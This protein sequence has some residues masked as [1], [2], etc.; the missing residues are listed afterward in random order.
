MPDSERRPP[1][2]GGAAAGWRHHVLAGCLA[3]LTLDGWAQPLPDAVV[4]DE[5]DATGAAYY[6]ASVPSVTPPSAL[7]TFASPYGGK[8]PILTQ[9]RLTGLHSGLLEWKP[10]PGGNWTW[11]IASPNFQIRNLTG[12]SNLVLFLNGPAAVPSAALPRIGLESSNNQRSATALLGSFLPA[13]LDGDTSTWQRVVVPLPAFAPFGSFTPEQFKAMFFAQG[14]TDGVTRTLWLDNVRFTDGH[15]P[16]PPARLTARAGDRSVALHWPRVAEPDIAGYQVYRAPDAGGPWTLLTPTPLLIPCHAD[17]AVT[18]GQSACYTVRAL[19][20]ARTESP[21]SST[22]TATPAAFVDDDAFLELVARTSFDFFWNEANPTN[23]LIRDRTT[24]ASPVSIAAVGFGLSGIV[25]AIERGWITREEGR[26]RVL[27]TLRTFRDGPQGSATTGMIGYQG[28]FYHFLHLNT[29]TRYNNSEL[30]SIDSALLFAGMLDAREFFDGGQP[31]E[32]EIRAAANLIFN[33][34]NWQWMANG[35]DSLTM[36]WQPT[37]GFI[38]ARWIGYNEAMLLYVLGLGA[39]ANPLPPAFWTRWVSG[40]DWRTHFGQSFV[41]FPP[42]FGHQYSHCWID[43]RHRA[44]AYMNG[45]SSS[46]FENSRRATLAQRAYCL[47]NPGGFASYGANVWGLTP[48]DGPTGYSARGAPP[49]END[50]GTIA[51]TAPGGS[52]PFAPEICLPALR[53]CYDQY[54]SNIWTGYGFRDAF[55]LT[56]NWWASD[57][58]GIDQGAILLMVENYR[59]QNVWRRFMRCPEVQRG[60]AAAGFTEFPLVATG[61]RQVPEPGAFTLRWEAGSG[62]SYQVEHSPNLREWFIPPDGFV[63]ASSGTASWTDQDPLPP[64][65]PASGTTQRFYRV[66]RLGPR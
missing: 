19:N 66:F 36:G 53:H 39:S 30:S 50:D 51:P 48:S 47:A 12:C 44:D 26:Q 23:G 64:T 2:R 11:F 45:R 24:P 8:L 40:Y 18:N 25:V 27:A 7:T 4:F 14:V 32:V 42:L 31:E 21:A 5:D 3:C 56:A 61:I 34:V 22:A 54:R 41:E 17:F 63:T 46:Y 37:S 43:F 13:G 29:A 60:L 49:A 28:W 38:A 16:V 20:Q 1:G 62:R 52:L 9:H 65:P 33:R 59:T 10:M 57:V 35:G 55:N 6:D 15:A 58:L